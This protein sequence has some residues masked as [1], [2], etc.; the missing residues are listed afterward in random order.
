MNEEQKVQLKVASPSND[1][2]RLSLELKLKQDDYENTYQTCCSKTGK[3]D[4]RLIH[5]ATKAT[6]TL[7][8][9]TFCFYQIITAEECDS[10]LPYYTSLISMVLAVWLKQ[11]GQDGRK[12]VVGQF[13]K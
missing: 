5:Y 12:S 9:L 10:L 8:V 3:T 2:R 13:T 7:L 1:K 4:K 6:L 11:D